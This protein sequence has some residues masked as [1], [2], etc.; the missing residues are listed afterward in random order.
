MEGSE[1]WVEVFPNRDKGNTRL[2]E[3]F[4]I[5]EDRYTECE[6][7]LIADLKNPWAPLFYWSISTMWPSKSILPR[8][9]GGMQRNWPAWPGNWSRA[10]CR[11]GRLPFLWGDEMTAAKTGREKV[12]LDDRK[13]VLT[14]VGCT[15]VI[16][17]TNKFLLVL[18]FQWRLNWGLNWSWCESVWLLLEGTGEATDSGP[19]LGSGWSW[20]YLSG[21]SS[22]VI[23]ES[24]LW[25]WN[26]QDWGNLVCSALK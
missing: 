19:M 14:M 25:W 22:V 9:H 17:I 26:G 18:I 7:K 10:R 24:W 4:V 3:K 21:L 15:Q 1:S 20:I 16:H 13:H 8:A 23:L 6:I 2:G 11:D 5:G 12:L